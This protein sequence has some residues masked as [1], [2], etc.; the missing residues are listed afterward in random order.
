MDIH[1]AW[2]QG[3]SISQIARETGHDRKTIR[4]LL[5]EG[6][7]R[8]RAPRQVASK[9]DPFREYLVQRMVVDKVTNAVS[10]ARQRSVKTAS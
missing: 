1:E 3:R 9:L 7:P 6:G 5:R 4:R 10:S 2:S 8:P